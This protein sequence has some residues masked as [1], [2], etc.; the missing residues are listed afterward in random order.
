MSELTKPI[1]AALR[2]ENYDDFE[3]RLIRALGATV[4]GESLTKALGFRSQGAF[5]K[6]VQRGRLSIRI[7]SIE[8]R[9]GR[10]AVTADVAAWL[11]CQRSGSKGEQMT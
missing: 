2:L 4:G 3:M 11:W 8:G 1:E 6:A 5:R 10:F 7:F 9:R